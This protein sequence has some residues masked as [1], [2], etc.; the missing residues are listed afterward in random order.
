MTV[1]TTQVLSRL[2]SAAHLIHIAV[3][4][5]GKYQVKLPSVAPRVSLSHVCR[6]MFHPDRNM[7]MATASPSFQSHFQEQIKGSHIS[8]HWRRYIHAHKSACVWSFNWTQG[9]KV[10]QVGEAFACVRIIFYDAS[11]SFLV[12]K[13]SLI[14]FMFSVHLLS[15][16][17][18]PRY[19]FPLWC[20]PFHLTF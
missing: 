15:P 13:T 9:T 16:P 4:I 10:S 12:P 18:T 8:L 3:T 20:Y 1:G 14:Q 11:C 5:L 19:L 7:N 17:N 6:P 2:E